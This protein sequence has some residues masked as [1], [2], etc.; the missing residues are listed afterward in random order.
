M[1]AP[2]LPILIP[3]LMLAAPVAAQTP[4]A[5]AAATALVDMVTPPD[6]SRAGLAAE[7]KAVREGQMVRAMLQNNAAFRTE[8]AKNQ[9]SF[10]AA[11]AR[12]GGMQADAL[13]PLMQESQTLSRQTAISAYARAFTAEELKAIAAFYRTPAGSKL[14]RTQPQIAQEV[15]RAVAAKVG[16][17]LQAAQKALAPKIQAELRKI[18]PAPPGK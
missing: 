9:P 1:R 7:V 11:V 3:A 4:E 12:M 8:A 16:P 6:R 5:T 13:G 17:R 18:M 10:N 15:N 14:L 2:L